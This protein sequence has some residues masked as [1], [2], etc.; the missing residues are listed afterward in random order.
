MFCLDAMYIML[1]LY[2]SRT[3]CN[4][5]TPTPPS[6][7][8]HPDSPIPTPPSRLPHPDSPYPNSPIPN[9]PSRLP[10]P[11]YPSPHPLSSSS[12]V[13]EHNLPFGHSYKVLLP[14]FIANVSHKYGIIQGIP[15]ADLL[16]SVTHLIT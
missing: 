9:S 11:D 7:L 12:F 4:T 8:P 6:R 5:S 2:V 13:N 1:Q 10:H 16:W 14:F 3:C 15:R